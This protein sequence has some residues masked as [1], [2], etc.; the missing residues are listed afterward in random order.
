[1][2][3]HGTYSVLKVTAAPKLWDT[4]TKHVTRFYCVTIIEWNSHDV[5]E[6]AVLDLTIHPAFIGRFDL[7]LFFFSMTATILQWRHPGWEWCPAE[8]ESWNYRGICVKIRRKWEVF[9]AGTQITRHVACKVFLLFVILGGLFN[10]KKQIWL[11]EVEKPVCKVHCYLKYKIAQTGTCFA[12]IILNY[13]TYVDTATPIFS[14]GFNSCLEFLPLPG[15]SEVWPSNG[16]F[17]HE[18]FANTSWIVF[19]FLLL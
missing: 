8:A 17:T 18:C 3:W 16:G 13:T 2:T 5:C 1:M 7:F 10:L 14:T 12:H 6:S 11:C 19:Y 15:W 4:A 9:G